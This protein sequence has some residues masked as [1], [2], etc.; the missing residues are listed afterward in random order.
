MT[1]KLIIVFA[2]NLLM[3]IC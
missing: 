1:E 3:M 2:Y